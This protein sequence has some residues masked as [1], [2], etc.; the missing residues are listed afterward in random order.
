MYLNSP[1]YTKVLELFSFC[2]WPSWHRRGWLLSS[3]Y[4][5]YNSSTAIYHDAMTWNQVPQQPQDPNPISSLSGWAIGQFSEETPHKLGKISYNLYTRP[6][7]SLYSSLCSP[8]Q[9]LILLPFGLQVVRNYHLP[10]LCISSLV[11]R[12]LSYEQKDLALKPAYIVQHK[13]G[14]FPLYCV[15]LSHWV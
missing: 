13:W 1:S 7:T 12:F 14:W 6:T 3:G 9:G 10:L 8:S 15:F 4:T 11:L 2:S 5:L